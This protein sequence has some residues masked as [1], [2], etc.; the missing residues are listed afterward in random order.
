MHEAIF[1]RGDV[2]GLKHELRKIVNHR[3]N[4]VHRHHICNLKKYHGAGHG[5]PEEFRACVYRI[6]EF[7]GAEAVSEYMNNVLDFA[8]VLAPR[9]AQVELLIV[10][11][12]IELVKGIEFLAESLLK[13]GK[14]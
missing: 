9:A 7:E 12:R 1:T 11:Y 6:L 13:K 2:Q 14:K 5:S 10:D 8:P 3:C 4:V